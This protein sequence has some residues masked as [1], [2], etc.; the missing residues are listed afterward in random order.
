MPLYRTIV[1]L[2]HESGNPDDKVVNV[3]HCIADDLTALNLFL[4]QITT[5]YAAIDGAYSTNIA[6]TGH[7]IRCYDLADPEPRA[8]V[9]DQG[10]GTLST[11]STSL[12]HELALCMSFQAPQ[13]SGQSQARR[14]GRLYLGPFADDASNSANG[15]PAAATLTQLGNA[16]Q[17]ILDASQAATTW[18]WAVYSPTNGA[19]I[20]VTN[21]WLDNAWDV[22]RRRGVSSTSRTTFT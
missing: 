12:P 7:R 18:A 6:S 4:T 10:A 19:A 2:V 20:E 3:W 9:V 13:Q 8:P 22:Q 17:A 16:I 1:E 5:F 21:A 15:F 14:R 11:G